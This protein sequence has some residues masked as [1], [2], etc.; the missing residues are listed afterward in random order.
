MARRHLLIILVLCWPASLW[1]DAPEAWIHGRWELIEDPDG[2][3][4]DWLEFLPNGDVFNIWQDGTRIGGF[5][6]VTHYDV[7]AVFTIDGR[8]LLTTFFFNTDRNEL[9]IVTSATGRESVYRK[10]P[11]P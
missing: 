7:K 9:R 3:P 10:L 8:D 5:Y 1:A 6:V 11:V 2:N 4:R